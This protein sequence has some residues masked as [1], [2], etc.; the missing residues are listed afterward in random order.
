[1]KTFCRLCEV[2]CGL[3]A[4]TDSEG[5]L[6]DLR[7]DKEH[8]VTAGF[9]CHKGLLAREVH[10]DPDRLSTPQRK[11]ELGFQPAGWDEAL[12]EI[13]G[14]LQSVIDEHGPDAVAVYLGNPSAFNALGSMAAGLFASS[15]GIER[16]F[17][18][19]TQDCANKFVVS[20][21]L[22]GSAEIHPV[23]DLDR[24]EYMLL[25]GTNPR[26][27]KLSFLSTP[28]PVG[29]LREARDRGAVIKFINPLA[30]DDLADVGETLQIRP[31]TDAFLLAAL[32]RESSCCASS[33]TNIP[34]TVSP[35]W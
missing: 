3:E 23:A 33:S 20:E 25:I 13:A 35:P 26:V 32:L 31:D 16:L 2:N 29:A 9:A 15:L 22:Y 24:S 14:R 8:P 4:S 21:I 7:P 10:H 1:M 19:G 17:N 6:T 12:P 34:P 27:S 11:G 28:D 30:L 5:R 18:A